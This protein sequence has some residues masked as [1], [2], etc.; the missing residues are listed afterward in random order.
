MKVVNT[1]KVGDRLIYYLKLDDYADLYIT[2][3]VGGFL[4]GHL[5]DF[6][7]STV[8]HIKSGMIYYRSEPKTR[9]SFKSRVADP[10]H[11]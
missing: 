5:R 8:L 1:R 3:R 4:P 2:K 10:R 6:L 7:A 9:P 11:F